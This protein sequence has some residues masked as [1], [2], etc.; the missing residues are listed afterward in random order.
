MTSAR[1]EVKAI[2]ARLAER[3]PNSNAKQSM[4]LEPLKDAVVGEMRPALL[5][6]LARWRSCS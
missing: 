5:L 2:A 4:T 3:Y 1:T 6:L